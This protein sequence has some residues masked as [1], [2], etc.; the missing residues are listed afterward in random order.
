MPLQIEINRHI[1]DVSCGEKFIICLDS[2][3][4]VHTVGQNDF[5]E[6]GTGDH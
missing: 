6:L 4:A 1:V 3:G 2:D 5:G